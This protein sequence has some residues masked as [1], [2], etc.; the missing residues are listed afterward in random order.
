MPTKKKTALE[1]KTELP[2]I[3]KELI[4]QFVKGP[5]TAEAIQDASM[6]F[7]KALIER[8]LGAELGHHL[9]YLRTRSAL[10]S[11]ITSAT[12]KSAKTVL[13]DDGPLRLEI[14][15]DRDGSFAPILIP[16]HEWRF[17]GFDDKIIAIYARGMTVREIR[18]FLLEQYGMDVSHD[19]ISS[20]T[21]AVMEEIGAGDSMT[22]RTPIPPTSGHSFHKHPDTDSTAIRTLSGRRQRR[23]IHY[24]RPLLS[25]RRGR[26]GAFI[27]A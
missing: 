24:H 3:P 2:S 23:I 14:P 1:A 16:K 17:T 19:F 5:M 15:R 13:T 4:D 10:M 20:V 9:G 7:K 11:R 12:V 21:D 22:I 25:K 27:H 18:A 8:A 26:R 6:A